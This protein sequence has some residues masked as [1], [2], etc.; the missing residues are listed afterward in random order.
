MKTGNKKIFVN[1]VERISYQG[2]HKQVY[3]INTGQGVVPTVSMKKSKEDNTTSQYQFPINPHTNKL[4]TGLN[5]LVQN[6]FEG[7]SPEDLLTTYRLPKQEVWLPILKSIVTKPEIKKQTLFEIRHGVEP[8]YYT[9]EI[10][11]SMT[12]MPSNMDEWGKKTFL[13][14][15]TL[16]LYPRPNPLDNSTPRQELLME[17]VYVLPH[18]ANN[19]AES[20]SAYHDWYIS[21]EHEAEIEKA[22]KQEIIEEAMYYL[23]KLKKEYGQFRTYQTAIVLRDQNSRP[24]VKGKVSHEA[25]G[26][27]LSF[28]LNDNKHQMDNINSFMK[29]IKLFETREGLERLDIQYLIQQAINTHVFGRRDGQY[30]W[31]SKAGTPDVYKLGSSFNEVVN[32]FLK[33]YKEF[34]PKSD[35]TNWYKDLIQEVEAKGIEL[36]VKK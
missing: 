8:D 4:E 36:N 33:E 32:F 7:L 11:Y 28:F 31:H 14:G 24:L 20:N 22:K 30:L 26:N 5:K 35:V 19:K 10:G 9:D 29:L 6:P 25:V 16:T 27:A 21:E 18:I 2:R 23:H 15:L 17:M 34:N 3:T 1:P 12:S 13:Q